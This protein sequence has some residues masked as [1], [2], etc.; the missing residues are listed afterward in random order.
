MILIFTIVCIAYLFAIGWCIYGFVKLPLCASEEVLPKAHFTIIIPFRNEAQQLPKLLKSLTTVDYPTN[1]FEIIFVNDAS[2]DSGEEIID[3]YFSN[4][5]TR[6]IDYTILQNCRKSA[7]PKKDAIT[8]AVQR[9]KY[10]W[11]VTTDA[12]CQVPIKWLQLANTT[13]NKKDP[14][15]LCGPILMDTDRSLLGSLQFLEGLSLQG[16]TMGSFGWQTPLLANGANLMYRKEA[17]VSVHG[18]EGNNHIASGDDIFLLE[19][20]QQKYSGKVHFLKHREAA[21]VTQVESHLRAV[22]EQRVRWS[23]KT[24]QQKEIRTKFFGL[25]VFFANLFFVIALFGISN[26]RHY[27]YE[28]SSLYLVYIFQKIVLD[29]V[30]VIILA[31]FF[32]KPF[33]IIHFLANSFLYPMVTLWVVIKSLFGSYHWKGRNF[34]K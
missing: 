28:Y 18:Y 27:N 9:A 22:I 34:R 24:S 32:K 20:V 13:I 14:V 12:D 2:I 1:N 19:K 31:D 7:S 29:I 5:A 30:L 26:A 6:A 3:T 33:S 25:I 21:V 10:A 16:V 8:M 15:M 4:Q 17:F 23:A 11:I